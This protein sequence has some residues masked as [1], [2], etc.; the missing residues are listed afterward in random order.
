MDIYNC[1]PSWPVCIFDFTFKN[2]NPK[3]VAL[4]VQSNLDTFIIEDYFFGSH[5]YGD[6]ARSSDYDFNSQG[7]EDL[8]I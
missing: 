3:Y 5:P 1:D 8:L 7:Q 4:R 2:I 6:G